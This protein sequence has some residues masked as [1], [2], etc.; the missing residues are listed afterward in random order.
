MVSTPF[1]FEFLSDD[2]IEKING[3]LAMTSKLIDEL[4]SSVL[5]PTQYL[6]SHGGDR[7]IVRNRI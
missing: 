6:I 1:Y 3:T 2:L 5:Q 4:T 7:M